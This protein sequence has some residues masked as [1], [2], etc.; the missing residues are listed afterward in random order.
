MNSKIKIAKFTF[1]FD[2]ENRLFKSQ[3]VQS[4]LA[5]CHKNVETWYKDVKLVP[6]VDEKR[7]EQETRIDEEICWNCKNAKQDCDETGCNPKENVNSIENKQII[8]KEVIHKFPK[9]KKWY[10]HFKLLNTNN[11]NSFEE[12]RDPM[13]GMEKRRSID[14]YKDMSKLIE[15]KLGRKGYNPV[16]KSASFMFS[17]KRIDSEDSKKNSNNPALLK[18]QSLDSQLYPLAEETIE[19]CSTSRSNKSDNLSYEFQM[20][21]LDSATSSG[22]RKGKQ[23]INIFRKTNDVKQQTSVSCVNIENRL[24]GNTESGK[25]K[26]TKP[27]LIPTLPK[28]E[29]APN[30]FITERLCAEFHVKTKVQKKSSSKIESNIGHK[31]QANNPK[32]IPSNP[33][34]K[35][36]YKISRVLLNVDE[37]PYSHVADEVCSSPSGKIENIYAEI[38]EADTQMCNKCDNKNC[39]CMRTKSTQYCYVKLGSN[40]DSV[41]QSDSDDAIYNTLR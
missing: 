24:S 10:Q 38:C 9:P 7:K 8:S 34:Q 3:R 17:T 21:I 41:I 23:Q 20:C 39:E 5:F 18:C 31:Y 11:E 6:N 35:E 33:S 27:D 12:L 28:E 30:S 25:L 37:I 15:E 13:D 40:G 2:S 22:E 1:G 32:K 4:A 36:E 14:R 26:K 29:S 19:R 16:K